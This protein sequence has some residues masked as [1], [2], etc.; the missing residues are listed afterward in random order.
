MRYR[1]MKR[2]LGSKLQKP[3]VHILFGA[4]QTGKT[5]LLHELEPNPS[6]YLNLA[7]P[8]ERSRLLQD[9]GTF[10]RACRA[11]PKQ[12]EPH[13]VLVDEAQA[14]PQVFD[15]VQTLY[16]ADKL[17]W[18]FILSGSTA[19]KLRLTGANLLPGRSLQHRLF[20][21]IFAERPPIDAS[22][23]N[24]STPLP[25][26][27]DKGATD[28]FPPADLSE[29]L[30]FGDLPG[31]V[32]LPAE[33]RADV[34]RS[35]A[36]AHLE[37]EIRREALVKDWGAFLRF[38]QFAAAESGQAVNFA[39]ISKEIGLT[40][41][42]VRSHYQLLEDMF[43]GFFV[44]GYSRSVRKNLTSTPRFFFFDLGIRHAAAGVTPGPDV[45]LA[46]PGRYFEQ[47][48]GIELWK[49]LGYLGQGRLHHYRTKDGAEVDFILEKDNRVTPIE[50][51]WTEHP[52]RSDARHVIAFLDEQEQSTE[53]GYVVC[54]IPRPELIHERVLAIPWYCL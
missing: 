40:A 35:Y 47:W 8:L 3:F 9:P 33:D 5:T 25:F 14:A 36:I 18:R 22:P 30:A 53:Y 20:P 19:R 37:E 10:D 16:D 39:K 48:V 17:R 13:V 42:T 54:R 11:L 43:I 44:P 45:A 7:D 23:K 21:L 15:S 31:I 26:A 2:H 46:D 51:K 29:R 49:R 24:V 28:L 1:W 27:R 52:D 50:V 6:L 38:L 34:L 12:R 32:L 4:R 41:V